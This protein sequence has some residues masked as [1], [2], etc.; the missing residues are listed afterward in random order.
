[1][2]VLCLK[3]DSD[4][5]KIGKFIQYEIVPQPLR[6]TMIAYHFYNPADNTPLYDPYTKSLKVRLPF[7]NSHSFVT[8]SR[9]LE[10]GIDIPICIENAKPCNV[11][12]GLDLTFEPTRPISVNMVQGEIYHRVNDN[13]LEKYSGYYTD[14]NDLTT[15]VNVGVSISLYFEYDI[16]QFD[17]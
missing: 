14:P 3:V 1:M 5:S 17:N 8:N 12:T 13:L 7:L 2:P 4:A 9:G 16:L 11:I 15:K 10:T 6:L